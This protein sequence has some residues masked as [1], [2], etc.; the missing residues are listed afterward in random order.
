MCL[1]LYY[2]PSHR[3]LFFS[4]IEVSD[5]ELSVTVTL[6]KQQCAQVVA[7]PQHVNHTF[8]CPVLKNLHKAKQIS[9][10][11]WTE[12]TGIHNRL[13]HTMQAWTTNYNQKHNYK[14]D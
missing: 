3:Q 5:I 7:Q 9:L 4:E 14:A 2:T 13:V 1:C 8:V 12:A 10:Q 11:R 6:A